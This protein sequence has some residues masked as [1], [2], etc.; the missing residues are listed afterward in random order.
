VTAEPA[1]RRVD[2]PVFDDEA[3]SDV[4]GNVLP[5]FNKPHQEL[6]F[7]RFAEPA[8]ARRLLGRLAPR[9]TTMGEVLQFRR[10]FREQ[11][12]RLGVRRPPMSATWQA[13]GISYPGL[14]ALLGTGEA[15]RVG[16]ESF[17]QGLAGRSA[18]LGDPTDPARDGHRDHW[19]VGGPG[20]EA[21]ALLVVASDDPGRL[22]GAVAET[23]AETERHG[24][25]LLLRQR[26]DDLPG[27]L[28]GHEHFGFR[29]GVSQPGI[30]GMLASGEPVTPRYLADDDPHALLF[31]K[32]GQP[33]LWPGQVLLGLPRQHPEDP[34]RP[35]EDL[36]PVPDWARRGSFL[37]CRRLRQDVAEFRRQVQ[38]GARQLEVPPERFAAMLVGR[39]P[40]GAPLSRTPA[41]DDPALGADE[42]AAN[43]FLY[44]DD[45]RPPSTR[46]EHRRDD[47][48]P[49]ARSDL[50]GRACPVVA[51]IRTMNPRDAGTD[52]G[53][54][55]DTFL[56]L[57]V[58]RGI[59]YGGPFTGD[60]GETPGQD[61][62]LLFLACMASIEDQFELVTRRWANSP[63]Q[64]HVGGPDPLI[65]QR[66]AT[67]DRTRTV[68]LPRPDGGTATVRLDHDVVVPTG[69]GYF[70]L[71]PVSAVA[72][73]LAGAP[74]GRA[75]GA[76]RARP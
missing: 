8:G 44:A 47:P 50:F 29:D 33:L 23:L 37:V 65:G 46:P 3:L 71:P 7:L 21:D 35:A 48:Y 31:G 67:G 16:D 28:A 56:R 10:A 72:G 6:L 26:G 38:A 51:H 76:L 12:R 55:G 22:D 45:T 61:R 1:D 41:A 2:E 9:L 34:L 30:R 4:Q 62:G 75:R 24:V 64:P 36:A 15:S 42:L 13:L 70:L 74:P 18:Y 69:G 60:P 68:E 11:R 49:A 53:A 43:H 27:G 19:L 39:W 54:P 73:V 52:L 57:M 5:G 66:E 63:V 58:R 59:P 17:R 14:V 32:P 20:N 25:T 40:S